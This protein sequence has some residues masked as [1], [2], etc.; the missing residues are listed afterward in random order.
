[1]AQNNTTVDTLHV[2]RANVRIP[3]TLD[4]AI[5]QSLR[6]IATAIYNDP[7]V[8]AAVQ[9]RGGY[10]IDFTEMGPYTGHTS[11]PG[12]SATIASDIQIDSDGNLYYIRMF[13]NA[14][15]VDQPT[16][17]SVIDTMIHEASHFMN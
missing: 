4:P 8:A 13:P 15:G 6:T 11:Q 16:R 10:T 14:D 7:L 5:Q 2:G 17:V 9:Q 3:T 12:R 1:M